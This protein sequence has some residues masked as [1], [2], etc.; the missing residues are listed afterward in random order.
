MFLNR[1]NSNPNPFTVDLKLKIR[2]KK[3]YSGYRE[4]SNYK[5]D[6]PLIIRTRKLFFRKKSNAGRST[7]GRTIIWTK[8]SLKKKTTKPVL[9][10]SFRSLKVGFISSLFISSFNNSP[11][12]LYNLSDGSYTYIKPTTTN[13]LFILTRTDDLYSMLSKKSHLQNYLLFLFDKFIIKSSIFILRRL[14][15]NQFI[16]LLE[17]YPGKK[18]QYVRSS[19]SKSKM[20]KMDTRTNTAI[21]KLPSGVKKVFSVYSLASL[22]QVLLTNRQL[23]LNNKAGYYSNKGKKPI[24]RGVAMNPVDHPHGGRTKAIKYPRTPWGK[25]TK[26][27]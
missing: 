24:V 6:L 22:G 9:N 5:S 16:S 12:A 2:S 25:T 15:R 3:L 26:F 17:L 13:Q 1:G 27:K 8:G 21:V 20:L 23:L 11:T 19:G 4:V 10:Y 7:L 14:P 18:I